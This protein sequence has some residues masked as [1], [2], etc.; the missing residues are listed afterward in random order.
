[1]KEYEI[2]LTTRDGKRFVDSISATCSSDA[3]RVMEQRYPG[4]CIWH[5]KV[6][7]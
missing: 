2:T 1:M 4:C 7:G 6:V 5:V 3:R